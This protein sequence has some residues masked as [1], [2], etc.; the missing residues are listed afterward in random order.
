MNPD[1]IEQ[2]AMRGDDIPDNLSPPQI[3]LYHTLA[4]LYARYRTKAISKSEAHKL[5]LQIVNAYQRMNS[6]YDQ[7]I[8][9]CKKY[10][11]RIKEGYIVNGKKILDKKQ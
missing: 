2:L 5:K 7:Y 11:D 4:A 10:Q 8:A 1:E 9:I 6:E 3:M